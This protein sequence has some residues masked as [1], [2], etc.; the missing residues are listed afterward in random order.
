MALRFPCVAHVDLASASDVA[1]I[2]RVKGEATHAIFANNRL[3]FVTKAANMS[4][5]L[6][7]QV[8]GLPEDEKTSNISRKRDS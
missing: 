7:E 8:R 4:M 1:E 5:I 3:K 2:G 6:R